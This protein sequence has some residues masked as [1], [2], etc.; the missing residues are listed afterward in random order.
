MTKWA[1]FQEYKYFVLFEQ[2]TI[3]SKN[4]IASDQLYRYLKGI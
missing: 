4:G 3:E 2:F 1:L